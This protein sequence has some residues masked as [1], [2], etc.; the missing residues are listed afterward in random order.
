MRHAPFLAFT[1]IELL[2]VIAI[3][4]MLAALLM[5]T[6]QRSMQKAQQTECISNLRQIGVAVQQYVADP[7]NNQQFPPIYNISNGTTAGSY[8]NTPTT[9]L[10]PL[11]CLSSYGVTMQLLTCPADTS[12]DPVYGSYLWSPVVQGD[13]PQ[14]IVFYGR[15]RIFTLN[16]LSRIALCYDKGYLHPADGHGST[17]F[18]VLRCDGHV[19]TKP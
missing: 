11:V 1:I 14:S 15:G 19:E 7:D 9:P 4:G 10:Q 12:P 18:N 3:I 16:N 2:V 6:M 8:T 17:S 5:P 13:T